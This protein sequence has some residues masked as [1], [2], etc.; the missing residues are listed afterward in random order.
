MRNTWWFWP[1]HWRSS[2][3]PCQGPSPSEHSSGWSTSWLQGFTCHLIKSSCVHLIKASL[4][5]ITHSPSASFS[6]LSSFYLSLSSLFFSS[7]FP[8]LPSSS[9]L[10]LSLLAHNSKEVLLDICSNN[11]L[12]K[13]VTVFRLRTS[14]TKF[15][16]L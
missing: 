3:S 12:L 11:I 1:S 6:F 15:I 5:G 2:Q 16:L 8:S 9:L 4:W 10:L 7:P 14:H 13:S